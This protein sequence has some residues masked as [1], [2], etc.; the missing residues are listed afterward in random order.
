[1]KLPEYGD[2]VTP[3]DDPYQYSPAWRSVLAQYLFSVVKW[4]E[5]SINYLSKTGCVTVTET[6]CVTVTDEKHVTVTNDEKSKNTQ[7]YAK[8]KKGK[9][10][11]KNGDV[12][13]TKKYAPLEPFYSHPEYRS[14]VLDPWVLRLVKYMDDDSKGLGAET[15]N[16]PFRL[17]M[18]WCEEPDSESAM[19]KKLDAL[20][21]TEIGIDIITL[22]LTGEPSAQ[23]A[24][25]AYE[26]LYFNC[27]DENFKVSRSLQLRM[28][29]AMPWGPLKAFLHKWEELDKEGFCKQDGRPIAKDSDVWRAIGATMG[30][31]PLIYVWRWEKIA[32]GLNDTSLSHMMDVALRASVSRL[33]S[34]LFTGYIAHEDAARMLASYTAHMKYITDSNSGGGDG[35][36]IEEA[37][38]AV[39][40][41]AAPKMRELVEGGSGMITGNEIRARIDSQLAIQKTEIYDAGKSVSDEIIDAQISNAIEG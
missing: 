6:E 38:M 13:V 26:K 5:D 1:M 19:R 32:H 15:R 21:L 28:K 20:L 36:E 33:I 24:I 40:G 41:A 34:E 39:L 31:E 3:V 17:A 12:A 2:I 35:L 23:P 18:R 9:R 8:K 10:K 16:I 27:R 30:Y 29:F 37:F 14:L 25:E 4:N 22:D 11:S 7:K